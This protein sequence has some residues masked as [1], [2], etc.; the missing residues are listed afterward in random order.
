MQERH[1][2]NASCRNV[3]GDPVARIFSAQLK[4]VKEAAAAA[5]IVSPQMKDKE[6][7]SKNTTVRRLV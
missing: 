5:T 2:A 4:R 3:P 1:K 6:N 7:S